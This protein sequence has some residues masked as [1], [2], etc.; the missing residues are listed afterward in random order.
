MREGDSERKD[1]GRNWTLTVGG[2]GHQAALG[3]TWGG[4]RGR[5]CPLMGELT[6]EGGGLQAAVTPLSHVVNVRKQGP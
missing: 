6:S 4:L 3:G 2:G 5:R 1:P